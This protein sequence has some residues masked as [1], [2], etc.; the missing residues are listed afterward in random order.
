[1]PRAADAPAR[2]RDSAAGTRPDLAIPA[3]RAGRRHARAGEEAR[4]SMAGHGR[5]PAHSRATSSSP[6]PGAAPEP[7]R[8]RRAASR[9]PFRRRRRRPSHRPSPGGRAFRAAARARPLALAEDS[10]P[11]R[12]RRVHLRLRRATRGERAGAAWSWSPSPPTPNLR[13]WPEDGRRSPMLLDASPGSYTWS[14]AA[15]ATRR[16][17][18][19]HPMKPGA[20]SAGP[21]S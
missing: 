6:S 1:M 14:S 2:S 19:L 21:L 18:A 16:S 10:S 3:G 4:R 7:R 17:R 5:G 8:G 11:P 9:R 12:Y 13:R 15:P 20:A